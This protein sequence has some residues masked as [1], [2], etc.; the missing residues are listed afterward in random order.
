MWTWDSFVL[1][2]VRK[3]IHSPQHV[4]TDQNAR[5]SGGIMW[6]TVR[7]GEIRQAPAQSRAER[8]CPARYLSAE[9]AVSCA[10]SCEAET[11]PVGS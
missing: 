11:V 10:L 7:L 9:S 5:S 8:V 3:H 6:C 4:E 2:Y 1:S